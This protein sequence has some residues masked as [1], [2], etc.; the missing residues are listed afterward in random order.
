MYL[1]YTF[2]KI[3]FNMCMMYAFLYG[4]FKD[5][6]EKKNMKNN[7]PQFPHHF[8]KSQVGHVRIIQL[9]GI[10]HLKHDQFFQAD[11]QVFV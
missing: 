5:R 1:D 7:I 4:T 6:F 8:A 2:I 10:G 3:D 9:S 11:S